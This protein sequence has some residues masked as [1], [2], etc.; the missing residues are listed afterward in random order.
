MPVT[1]FNKWFCPFCGKGIEKYKII[2]LFRNGPHT[3]IEFGCGHYVY[4]F[5][6]DK[7]EYQRFKLS[8]PEK[9]LECQ[10]PYDE[11]FND[12][13][14]GVYLKENPWNNEKNYE[15]QRGWLE[16]WRLAEERQNLFARL[17]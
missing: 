6:E 2:F 10:N 11:G 8:Y 15:W 16:A 5:Y 13:I 9:L 3:R 12:C 17:S 1:F 14:D 7:Y 4:D